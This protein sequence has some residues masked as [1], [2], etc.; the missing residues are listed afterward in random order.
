MPVF[1]PHNGGFMVK[2]HENYKE[3]HF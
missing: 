3:R 1:K 2:L